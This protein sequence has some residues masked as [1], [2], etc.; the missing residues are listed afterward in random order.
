M[1]AFYPCFRYLFQIVEPSGSERAIMIADNLLYIAIFVFV[2]MF[3]GLVLTFM[4]FRYGNPKRQ[5]ERAE[6]NPD[7]AGGDMPAR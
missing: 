6:K 2:I 4:E 5:Q 3:I 1:G 7:S